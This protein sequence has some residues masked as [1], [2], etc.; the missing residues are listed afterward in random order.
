MRRLS[1]PLFALLLIIGGC[2]PGTNA[3]M[4]GGAGGPA[5]GEVMTAE[6]LAP[7]QGVTLFDALQT[8][9][10][11]WLRRR[12]DDRVAVWLDGRELGGQSELRTILV[13]SVAEVRYLEPRDAIREYGVGYSSGAIQV[14]SR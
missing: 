4:Q 8:E 11:Q 7:Y 10:G 5:A 9:R 13:S 6:D 2:A 3:A 1:I 12:G 14:T